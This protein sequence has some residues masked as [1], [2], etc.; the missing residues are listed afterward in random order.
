M[1]SFGWSAGTGAAVE[2]SGGASSSRSNM[3]INGDPTSNT[4]NA[5]QTITV[6][7]PGTQ[8]Y[9]LAGWVWANAVPDRSGDPMNPDSRNKKCG[10]RATITYTDGSVEG[11]YV[12][13][14]P[15][16]SKTWQF[17]STTIVPKA[18]T[19][20]VRSIQV[21]AA[22]EENA[23]VAYFDN[24]SL[25]REAAQSMK[26]DKD[27]N[28]I[29]VDSTGLKE[30]E[31]TY[32]NG[33]LIKTVTGGKGTYEY[34]YDT[35][36]KHRLKSV[37]NSLITQAMG[38]D[39]VG[40]VTSTTLSGSGSKKITTSAEYGGSG[41][42]LTSVTDASGAEVAYAYSNVN[43]QMMSLPTSITDPNGTVTTS[44]YD[45]LNRVTETGI[46][47]TADVVYTYGSGNLSSVKRSDS[48]A[49]TQTY[50]FTYDSFG[51]MLT[52]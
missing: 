33:N 48:S 21:T 7:L 51:N 17:T 24:I 18:P 42:R 41:N 29:R 19:K 22:Y 31:N 13:F 45:S 44:T 25:L 35:T 39:G 12:P 11:H 6:N 32:Q 43:S 8:T 50:S 16:L 4:T 47:G 27:G 9:V 2:T 52:L 40:N 10:L 38:Y 14:N 5:S 23:Y 3:R 37:T 34:T 26:Y 20:T 15:D 1:S 46:A 30:D 36:Y 28:L 49:D